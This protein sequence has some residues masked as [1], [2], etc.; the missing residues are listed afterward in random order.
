M[1]IVL[2]NALDAAQVR[3][4][5]PGSPTC[6]VVIT[7]R[8]QLP[9]LTAIEAARPLS[10]DTLTST[11]ARQFL[12]ERLGSVRLAA[13]RQ[14]TDQ[15]IGACARLPLALCIVAARAG[16]RPDLELTRIATDL[17]RQST[18][19]AFTGMTDP[20]SDLRAA[21]SWSY[22][23]LNSDAARAF[24]LASLLPGTDLGP[25]AVADLTGTTPQ[26]ASRTLDILARASMIQAAGQT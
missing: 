3:P 20:A 12:A 18:L 15:I 23:Q 26:I 14:A 11:E 1:L 8:N 13:N 22:R 4:L 5:L 25:S 24:R 6:R 16:L 7:S 10:V 17:A 9:G 19:D 2:D 21:F